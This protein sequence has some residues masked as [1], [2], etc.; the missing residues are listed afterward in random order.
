[1]ADIAS[2]EGA[3]D[4]MTMALNCSTL[5]II[6][7]V[8]HVL[9]LKN[10]ECLPATEATVEEETELPAPFD[11]DAGAASVETADFLGNGQSLI[12]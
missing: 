4:A 7:F 9:R 11:D 3:D 12:K 6:I 8:S 10:F 1:M 2:G 5:K